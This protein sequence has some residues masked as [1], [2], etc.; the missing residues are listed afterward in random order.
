VTCGT[1]AS[2][3]DI[4]GDE[5]GPRPVRTEQTFL[6]RILDSHLQQFGMPVVLTTKVTRAGKQHKDGVS[7]YARI[8]RDPVRD[9]P[10]RSRI[11]RTAELTQSGLPPEVGETSSGCALTR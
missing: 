5:E 4:P 9:K 7:T 2:S 10:R 3:A 11:A 8:R 1:R 6:S